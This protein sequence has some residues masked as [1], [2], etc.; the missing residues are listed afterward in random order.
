L[1]PLRFAL[2]A[3]GVDLVTLASHPGL[4]IKAEVIPAGMSVTRAAELMGVG[5]PALSNLLNGNAAL[6]SD[7]AAR[8]EKAFKKYTRKE[9]IDMQAEY[10]AAQA[11]GKPLSE[12]RAYVP[13]FLGIRANQIE[14][15]VTHN[16]AA[17]A[18]LSI[19]L[20]TLVHST[21]RGLTKVD[22]PG[23]D[24]AERAGWDGIVEAD[25]GTPWVPFGRSGWE[26]GTTEN[27]KKKAN[28]D[29]DKSVKALDKRD[30]DETTFIF[31]TPRHWPGNAAWIAEAKAKGR[32]KD[33]RAY[34]A[35]DL[36]QWLEQSIPGQVWFANETHIPAEDIR[37]LDKC[38]ADWANICIPPLTGVLFSSAIDAAKR[39][40][41]QR[42]SNPPDGSIMIGADSTEEALAFLAQVFSDRAS[43]ELATY[44]DRVLVFDKPG[45]LPRLTQSA[46][47]FIAVATSREVERELAPHTKSMHSIV[48]YPRNAANSEPRIVL[49]PIAH[50]TFS[51]A[52]AE[53]GKDRDEIKRLAD[54]SG[55]S[56]TVLRRRLATGALRT[57]EWADVRTTASSLVPFLFAG[58]WHSANDADR[59]ALS[60]LAGDKPYGELEKEIQTLALLNDAPVWSIGAYRG[61]ISKIDL[62]Y[63]IADVVTADDLKHYFQ[64]AEIV[65]GEDD[66]ALDL[67]ED[68]RWA[69]SIY[70]KTR[71]FSSA[72]R[73][74]I[75]ETLVL[76]SIYGGHLFKRRLGVDTEA[77]A[78]LVVRR[79]LRTPLTARILE[80]N[81]RDLPTYAEAAPREFL[82]IIERDL[83][84]DDPAVLGLLRP[85]S[86]DIF[87]HSPSRTGLLWA[88]EGLS[89]SPETLP[90]AASILARLAQIE[91]NDNWVNKPT[92]SLESIFRAWMPQTAANHETRVNLMKGLAKTFPMVAWRLCV[93][94]FGDHHGV[95]HYS[96]KPRW[97]PDGYGF[98]EPFSTW[99][100]IH[101]FV[102]E[103]VEM[104]LGWQNHTLGTL[105]DLVGRLQGLLPEHQTRVWALIEA[106]AKDKA[107]DADKAAMREKIRISTL[108]RRAALR[109]KRDVHA[110]ALKEAAKAAY[111]ALEPS[112]VLNKH[113]WLFREQWV[114]ESAD[115]I[116]EDVDK[117][118]FNKREERIQ[119][120]RADALREVLNL[121]GID[122]LLQLSKRGNA[123]WV[124]GAIAALKGVLDESQLV[125]LLR[126][127]LKPLLEGESDV[128]TNRNLIG[129]TLRGIL[130]AATRTRIVKAVC[131][132]LSEDDA[133][134]LLVLCPYSS[135]TWSLVDTLGEAPQTKY[136]NEVV[137]DWLPHSDDENI[138]GV[139]RLLRAG[140]PRAA[141][142]CIRFK[143]SG[144]DAQVLYRL[145]SDMAAGGNDKSGEYMLEH[146]NV[147]QAFKH[148]NSS[149]ALTLDQKAGLEFAFVD[150]LARPWDSRA[151]SY[152][153]PNLERYVEAHP[154]LFVQAIAWA[155]K[156]KDGGIDPEEVS[157][158]PNRVKDM[159]ERG[160]KL[161]EALQRIPGH[162]EIGKL[163]AKTLA[164][165]I[166]TVRQSASELSRIDVADMCIGTLLAHAPVGSDDIWP[167]EP[168]RQVME[169]VRSER[170][171]RGAHTGVYNSRGVV[172]RGEGGDQERDLAAKYRKWSLALRSSYPYVATVLLMEL[173]RTYEAEASREDTAASLRG[174]MR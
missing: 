156:R 88:L 78:V 84:S 135:T 167:C 53:M 59:L 81:D 48:V 31:V 116:E 140:R 18:R 102:R 98:G 100:P 9:L 125:E 19:L 35:S 120:L 23:N 33:V 38:W 117:I 85:A 34:D 24:D 56:L 17:R 142:S 159:A 141:F 73:E 8:L 75:S 174:R 20:R 36:E 128:H 155:Y 29:F 136:W 54:E 94:Q 138:Q 14:G 39:G 42:F 148:L 154:E 173:V 111:Q 71:E 4:R 115:E 170:L 123:A 91:I 90:R 101:A 172:W 25:E 118:D 113:A 127:A 21:G 162:D 67:D 87:G 97:R 96:H 168:V 30:R 27:I 132:D 62:L 44:R 143:P 161:L 7:M 50:E 131:A 169:E 52:L 66:P 68:K 47:T 10:D 112:D 165:W 79:L 11:K 163:N 28:D 83:Q 1:I 110:R 160:Y 109:S 147:E 107:N 126:T 171:M 166:S 6:S 60:L 51:K 134:K 40:L 26:F 61:V 95:G 133:V 12:T 99:A 70:D 137:P 72:F 105:S 145:L 16:I 22:F 5:R 57:P 32:W 108:S 146:Y 3:T 46:Q 58:A 130:D 158:P 103:M 76:L 49:G 139:E 64:M 153:I 69:A 65:L 89:W 41:A 92:N 77:E 157:V 150:V 55:R 149:P 45:V 13:P 124:L 104:A 80:A 114:E 15:W 43:E 121:H 106:W 2:L 86:T 93:A 119:Q 152:G 122:G 63:A 129:G 37:S 74:G 164:K 151:E 82:S 144:L